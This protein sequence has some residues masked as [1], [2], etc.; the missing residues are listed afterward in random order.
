MKQREAINSNLPTGLLNEFYAAMA[1]RGIR[2]KQEAL[3]AALRMWIDSDGFVPFSEQNNSV[4]GPSEIHGDVVPSVSRADTP[5]DAISQEFR[6]WLSYLY[7]I[8][9][10]N[11]HTAVRAVKENLI[12]FVELT[13]S[14]GGH[15]P[16]PDE[17]ERST[18]DIIAAIQESGREAEGAANELAAR[19]RTRRKTA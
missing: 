13:E 3:E 1:K 18:E 10:K 17:P 15:A 7:Y 6:K 12:A 4:N 11:H 16:P 2:K 14:G 8:L 9:Q 5:A 19:R